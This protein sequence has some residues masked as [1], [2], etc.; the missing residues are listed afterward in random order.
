[1][2]RTACMDLHVSHAHNHHALVRTVRRPHL[3]QLH[4]LDALHHE[5]CKQAG[6][7]ASRGAISEEHA[8]GMVQ[9]ALEEG[10]AMG[11]GIFVLPRA[12]EVRTAHC[13]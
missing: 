7:Q 6:E 1:M 3:G 5:A 9:L 2:A 13:A 4:P 12:A 8:A 10:I 11:Q